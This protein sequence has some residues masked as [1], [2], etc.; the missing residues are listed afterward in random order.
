MIGACYSRPWIKPFFDFSRALS[1]EVVERA[2]PEA[3][4]LFGFDSVP[5]YTERWL[6]DY[7]LGQP[8][9]GPLSV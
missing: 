7:K 1:P 8:K 9:A 5:P 3:L 4:R 2:S 6:W